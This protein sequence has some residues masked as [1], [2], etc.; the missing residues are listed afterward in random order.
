MLKKKLLN[1]LLK[2]LFH[3]IVEEDV[4]PWSHLSDAQREQ[5][6]KEARMISETSYWKRLTSSVKQK[7]QQQMFERSQTYEDMYFGKATLY[8]VDLLE[9]RLN[10]I[11]KFNKISD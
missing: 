8:V 9:K 4:V 6:A 2:D 3:A 11:A 7:A 1:W 10:A 5:M